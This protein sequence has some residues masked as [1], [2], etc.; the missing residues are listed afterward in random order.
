MT[1]RSIVME[2]DTA[3]TR[4]TDPLSSHVGG[5][6][7]AANRLAVRDAVMLL[8]MQ[9]GSLTGQELND[10]YELRAT[11][12]SWPPVHVDSPR[13]RAGELAAEGFLVILN[14][15]DP[16]GTPHEYAIREGSAA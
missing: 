7:S 8:L 6:V 3:R 4:G 2:G 13:K 10:L 5:D 16:R 15:D 12:Q 14:A 1:T 11:R 9:E